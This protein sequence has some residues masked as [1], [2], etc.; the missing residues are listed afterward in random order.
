VNGEWK[1]IAWQA[2]RIEEAKPEN[3]QPD[4]KK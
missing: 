1:V 2:T 4:P 3:P